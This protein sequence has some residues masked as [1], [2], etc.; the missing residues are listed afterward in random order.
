MSR[1]F[2]NSSGLFHIKLFHINACFTYFTETTQNEKRRFFHL[3][4]QKDVLFPQ[5]LR[6]MVLFSFLNDAFF[7]F[8]N[9]LYL[10]FMLC[11]TILRYFIVHGRSNAHEQTF[12]ITSF[13]VECFKTGYFFVIALFSAMFVSFLV[14][15]LLRIK[16][17]RD[18]ICICCRFYIRDAEKVHKKRQTHRDFRCVL[19]FL[20]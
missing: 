9:N 2:Y 11:H 18:F 1:R 13:E 5:V 16:K 6:S 8:F 3:T 15:F 14:S 12:C 10:I 7:V 17:R 4:S 20:L 19:V